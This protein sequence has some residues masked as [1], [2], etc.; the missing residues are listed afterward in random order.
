MLA[1]IHDGDAVAEMCST[2]CEVVGNED[3]GEAELCLQV[4]QQVEDLR[5]HRHVQRRDRL[6]ADDQIRA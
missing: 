4:L 2:T 5:L 1:E 6:V 3:V